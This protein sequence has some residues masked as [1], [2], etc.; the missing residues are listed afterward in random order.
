MIEVVEGTVHAD[1]EKALVNK[2]PFVAK[3]PTVGLVGMR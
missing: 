2:A 3:R 1:P